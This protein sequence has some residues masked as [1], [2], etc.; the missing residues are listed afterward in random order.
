MNDGWNSFQLPLHLS[1]DGTFEIIDSKIVRH[2]NDSA[3]V[4]GLGRL[5]R[6]LR[7]I[8]LTRMST[9][10]GLHAAAPFPKACVIYVTATTSVLVIR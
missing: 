3:V 9:C 7:V 8:T 2:E 6:I 1:E 10:F 4:D 5:G